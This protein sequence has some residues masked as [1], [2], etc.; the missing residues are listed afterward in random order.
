MRIGIASLGRVSEDTGGKNYILHWLAELDRLDTGHTFVLF[1]SEGE[2]EALSIGAAA[3]REIVTIQGTKKTPL[4]KVFGEQVLLPLAA[5]RAELDVL[6][7]PGNFAPIRSTIPSVVNIRATAHFYGA[8]YGITRMRRII[9]KLLMPMSARAAKA[10]ITPSEDIKQDVVRY[11]KVSPDKVHVIPHGVD[12]EIF[13]PLHRDTEESRAVLQRFALEKGK[14]LLYVSALWE[15]KNHERLIQAHAQL[16]KSHPDLKLVIAGHGT[17]TDARHIEHLRMLPAGLG[18]ASSVVFT[19]SL[20]QSTLKY[21]YTASTA[22]I[23]PSLYESF[24]NPIF[25]A[26]ASGVPVATS[27]V[28]S[29][30]EIVAE[31]GLMFD[32]M[33]VSAILGAAR[34]LVENEDL[35]RKLTQAGFERV[36]KF[37]WESSVRRTLSL[38]ESVS[39]SERS[40]L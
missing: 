24:G 31:A 5:K 38:I 3:N 20:P 37:T 21:L 22:F 34:S 12:T 18:T 8:K 29:F 27:N 4:H 1:F 17:G 10:I 25:E 13:S 14:Y 35:R 23:F 40:E 39:E 2:A 6:Y 19:G 30:P 28:H 15:Y 9:R 32:P 7:C 16:V 11:C 33:D 36:K 26:W